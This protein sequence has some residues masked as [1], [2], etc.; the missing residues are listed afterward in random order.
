M[1]RTAQIKVLLLAGILLATFIF[2]GSA[3]A[4]N[5]IIYGES[6]PAGTVVNQ[7]VILIGQ[8][9]A[10]EGTVNGNVFI[11]GNQVSITGT[12]DGSLILIAQNAA[13]RGEVD[14]SVY[15]LALTL[16]LS[17]GAALARDLY[18]ATVSLTSKAS[19]RIDRHLYALGL[20]AGLNGQVGSDLHTAIGPLQLY[21]GLMKLIGFEELSLKLHIDLPQGEEA[22][23]PQSRQPQARMRFRLQEPLPAFNWSE[24]G[25]TLLRS[26]SILSLVGLIMIWLMRKPLDL[27]GTAL[28]ARPWQ[29][30]GVGLLVLVVSLNLFLVVFLVG[31]LIFA[32]GLGLNALGFWQ[33]SVVLWILTYA[34][35]FIATTLWWLFIVCGTKIVVGFH[36]VSWV[37]EKFKLQ[38]NTWLDI[39]AV[40]VGSLLFVLLR[41][42]PYVGWG[43]GLL[44]IAAGMGASWAAYRKQAQPVPATPASKGAKKAK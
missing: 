38:R 24:W 41:S 40:L 42:I 33:I 36:F 2:P 13:I 3:L 4:D 15:S 35:L 18:A 29:S 11:L 7:D 34:C 10:I 12:V 43:I 6:I 9:V 19:S 27:S 44:V 37:F 20:D 17:E 14:G 26:W 32:L 5:G 16:E 28:R 25:L 21:N 22:K 23:P 39:M 8:N 31:V 30:L 1:R